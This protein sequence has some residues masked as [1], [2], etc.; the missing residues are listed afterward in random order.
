MVGV[1]GAQ[2]CIS[3]VGG[4]SGGGGA[5]AGDCSQPHDPYAR[6]MQAR[7]HAVGVCIW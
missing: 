3:S 6:G 2:C 7:K 4:C 5:D 1:A